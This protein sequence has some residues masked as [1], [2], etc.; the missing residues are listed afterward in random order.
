MQWSKETGILVKTCS[1]RN[2]AHQ[3]RLC[4]IY[5]MQIIEDTNN[6]RYQVRAYKPGE[7]TINDE[8]YT[9]SIV[10]MSDALITDWGPKTMNEITQVHINQVLA[11]NPEIVLIGTGEESQ[12]PSQ[13]LAEYDCMTTAAACRTFIALSADGRNVAAALL[14]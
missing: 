4:Y 10:V 13:T 11:L 5:L 1:N 6:S 12:R 7:I 9:K 3:S 8:K 14:I 2:S